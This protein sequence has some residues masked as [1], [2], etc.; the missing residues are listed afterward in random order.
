MIKGLVDLIVWIIEYFVIH[1][2][3]NKTKE[4]VY[5]GVQII[6]NET[7]INKK[8]ECLAIEKVIIVATLLT[9]ALAFIFPPWGWMGVSENFQ[10]F[11]FILSKVHVVTSSGEKLNLLASIIW[12]TL[13]LEI[14]TILFIGF[15]LIWLRR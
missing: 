13:A 10:T 14:G 5:S 9:C 2:P 3:N 11:A 15:A 8:K 6:N 1:S 12:P 7:F 4:K